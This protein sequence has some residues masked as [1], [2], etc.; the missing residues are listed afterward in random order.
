MKFVVKNKSLVNTTY[1]LDVDKGFIINSSK[2]DD[3]SIVLYSHK[4]IEYYIKRNFLT[5]YKK[6]LEM[7]SDEDNNPNETII[8]GEIERLEK[9]ILNRY[10]KYLSIKNIEKMFKELYLLK[11]KLANSR[12]YEYTSHKTTNKSR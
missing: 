9:L 3:T 10:H 7:L 5:K 2:K 12:A 8:L 4:L 11:I 1:E 6:L